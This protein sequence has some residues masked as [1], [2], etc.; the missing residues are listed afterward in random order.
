[1]AIRFGLD[2]IQNRHFEDMLMVFA[3]KCRVMLESKRAIY[4]HHHNRS[5]FILVC[6][7]LSR[8]NTLH[9]VV[10]RIRF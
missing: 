3:G 1:M 5:F 4:Y 6:Q 9:I 8:D 7:I 2:F 10:R